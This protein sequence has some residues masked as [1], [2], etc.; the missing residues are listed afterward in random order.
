MSFASILALFATVITSVA[1]VALTIIM[2]WYLIW[3]AFLSKFR[4]VRELLGQGEAEVV[5]NR[6]PVNDNAE[7]Q[8]APSTHKKVRTD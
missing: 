1:F 2:G 4:L 7:E 3:K 5:N 8:P 6:P